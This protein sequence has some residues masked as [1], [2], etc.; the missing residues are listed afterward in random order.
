[1]FKHAYYCLKLKKCRNFEFRKR[2]F[3]ELEVLFGR[4]GKKYIFGIISDVRN[5]IHKGALNSMD[6]KSLQTSSSLSL[7]GRKVVFTSGFIPNRFR[8]T[9]TSSGEPPDAKRTTEINY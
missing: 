6:L 2:C 9:G 7:S 3:R 5:L 4:L 1:M 8:L